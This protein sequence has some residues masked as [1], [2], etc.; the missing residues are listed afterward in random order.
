MER[1]EVKLN[2]IIYIGKIKC[3]VRRIY[4]SDSPFGVGE[5]VFE[6]DKPTSHDFDWQD[7]RW[8]FPE[9]PDYGGYVAENDPFLNRLRRS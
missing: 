2:E 5:V 9:R 1:P 8:I 6:A 4:E 3:I 7:G